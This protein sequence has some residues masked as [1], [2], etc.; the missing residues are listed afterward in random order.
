MLRQA[1]AL[2]EFD[3]I[4]PSAESN[5]AAGGARP[6]VAEAACVLA[7]AASDSFKRQNPAGRTAVSL[8]S[9][10]CRLCRLSVE[11]EGFR[12]RP[13]FGFGSPTDKSFRGN[14]S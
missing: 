11:E 4:H 2:P 3:A 10:V 12:I 5:W 1:R 6:E 14:A 9:K 7:V 8:L 13:P